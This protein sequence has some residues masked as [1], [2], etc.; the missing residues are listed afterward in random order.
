MNMNKPLLLLITILLS[1]NLFSQVIEKPNGCFA[2]T[3]G[4]NSLVM[5]HPESRGVL[6][7]EK[8]S[9]IETKP[10]IYN[11]TELDRKIETVTSAGLKYSLAVAGGAFGSPNWLTESLGVSYHEFEYQGKSWVL[12]LWWNSKCE[13]KLNELISELGQRYSS[14]S[15]LS[16]VYVTQMTVNGIEGH[17]NGV[18]MVEFKNDGYT[19]ENWIELAKKTTL[20]F[21]DAFPSKP[22]VFEIHEIDR[23]TT[24]VNEIVRYL[25][26][27][28]KLC[29]R[30]G[31]GMWWLSGKDT[32]QTNLITFI[33]NY[34]G[35][36]Y[37]QV[38]GRSDQKQ[39]F[40]DSSY[41][42]VFEQA[43]ELRI[44][45]IEPWPYEFQFNTHDSI[46]KD[47]NL[48]ADQNFTTTDTCIQTS[49]DEIDSLG[50]KIFPNP[51]SNELVVNINSPYQNLSIGIYDTGGN[52]INEYRNQRIIDVN[53]LSKG[54]YMI[55]LTVD[56]N[57][58]IR[59]RFVVE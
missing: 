44:R 22:I 27:H 40:H 19:E 32:Y 42:T 17:L 9:D 14:D 59:K 16:H 53:S 18:N 10:G 7:I 34:E 35:D 12:P 3:N 55:V 41:A 54:V 33:K 8:W 49:I 51:V 52:K 24:V 29:K 45:Y 37:A 2:G 23:D 58:I 38:I 5:A 47:F 20:Q 4:I 31:I 26:N 15:M 1:A 13:I 43:K 25:N 21:A 48:W 46:I 39:R 56:Q 11:F 28:E 50:I 6:L 30:F 36:K 57:Q